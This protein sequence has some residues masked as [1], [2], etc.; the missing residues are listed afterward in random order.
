MNDIQEKNIDELLEDVDSRILEK[1]AF[2]EVKITHKNWVLYMI[3][4]IFSILLAYIFAFDSETKTKFTQV[5]E[6]FLEIEIAFI[7]IIFGAYALFQ[8][9]VSDE[10]LKLMSNTENNMLKNSNKSFL[11]LILLYLYAIISNIFLWLIL[12]NVAEDFLLFPNII[13]D[14][15]LCF[16]GIGIY[17]VYSAIILCELKNFGINLYKMFNTYNAYKIIIVNKKRR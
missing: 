4:L 13:W 6:K 11:N 5:V 12:I 16:F 14:N 9:M 3:I 10:F 17:F 7:A 1:E 15:I 8:A 2:E